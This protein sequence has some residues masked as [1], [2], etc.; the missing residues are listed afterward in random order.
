MKSF[1]ELDTVQLQQAHPECGLLV[2][3]LGTVVLVHAQGEA[4]E[5]EFV[6]ADGNTQ[7]LLTLPA[8]EVSKPLQQAA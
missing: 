2:G 3:A 7:A 8:A 5:V 4:Y 6:Q 1:A